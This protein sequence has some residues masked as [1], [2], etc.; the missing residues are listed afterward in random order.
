MMTC[1]VSDALRLRLESARKRRNRKVRIR[2]VTTR[3]Q[4]HDKFSS[5]SLPV[6]SRLCLTRPSLWGFQLVSP[7]FV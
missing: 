1:L 7:I 6:R 4:F 5:K 2:H 3:D